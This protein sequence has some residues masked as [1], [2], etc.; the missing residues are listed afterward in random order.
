MTKTTRIAVVCAACACVAA[1]F[2]RLGLFSKAAPGPP[3]GVPVRVVRA[4]RRDSPAY[5]SNIATVQAFNTVLVRGRVDGQISRVAFEEGADVKR[6]DVLVELDRR[7]FEAQWHAA[8]AQKARDS[9]QLDNARRDLARYESLAK[10]D[11]LAAQT[12][13]ATRSQVA[14]FAAA[15]DVDQAQ[16]DM[17][18]LQLAYATI[19]APIDG[20]T[21]ARLV[22]VGNIVH[23]G[24]ATG[25]VVLTQTHPIALSFSLPQSTLPSVRAQQSRHPLRVLAMDPGSEQAVDAGQLTLIDNQIDASTGTFHCKA[26]FP[27]AKEALWPGQFV[28]ARVLLESVPDTVVIPTAAVQ[29]G[30]HGPYVYL[31]D[32]GQRAEVRDV[33][34]GQTLEGETVI[35]QGLDGGETVVVEGQFQLEPRA[36]VSLTNS[37]AATA[38]A[39]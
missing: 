37:V 38:A 26:V 14:Q 4:A 22:D 33:H 19:T 10:L 27:N 29:A 6:G 17:A 8:L 32:D 18:R 31:V 12:L 9:A 15:V 34:V 25:L 36:L 21:G 28:T 5:L 39:R 11:S 16:V 23:A 35:L 7:P 13:D 20:R 30:A 24:D 2:W 3:K 1:V